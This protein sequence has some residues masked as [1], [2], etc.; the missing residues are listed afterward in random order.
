MPKFSTRQIMFN[1]RRFSANHDGNIAI[2]SALAILPVLMAAGAAVDYLGSYELRTS[3]QSAV[4]AAALASA[5][6]PDEGVDSKKALASTFFHQNSGF[7]DITPETA[8]GADTVQVSVATTSKTS[9]LSLGGITELPVNVTATATVISKPVCL[10]SLNKTASQAIK[11]WGSSAHVT[12][13]DCVVHANSSSPSALDNSSGGI[14]KAEAFCATGGY[15][16]S[17]FDPTPKTGCRQVKDPYAG[18]PVPTYAGC[19]FNNVSISTG[20]VTLTPGV[21]CGGLRIGSANVTLAPGLYIMADGEFK[22]SGT[23]ADISGTG[24]TIYLNGNSSAVSITGGA[25]ITLTASATGQYAGLLFV[26][27]PA[28][29]SSLTSKIN[30]HSQVKLVGA[31]YF[32]AQTLSVG[33]SGNFGVLSPYMTFVADIVELHGNGKITMN[34]DPAA[35]GFSNAVPRE[36]WGVRL[37]N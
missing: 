26:Q 4:D 34:F 16:G 35:A 11:I 37:I 20:T 3:I 18:L 6:S 2:V 33:G 21:Y 8:V 22:V 32:P 10:L 29:G 25:R 28:Y 7:P 19:D 30:G 36:F 1:F 24:I 17:N 14:S 31:G 12:A 13:D 23:S 9:F 15:S 27:N 5:A